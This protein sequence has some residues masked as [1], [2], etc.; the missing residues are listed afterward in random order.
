MQTALRSTLFTARP[1]QVRRSV[2]VNAKSPGTPAWAPE[3]PLWLPGTTPPAHLD[4]T[5][6]GDFGFDPLNLGANPKALERYVQ[7]EL[8]NG[9]WAMLGVAG[10]IF[11]ELLTRAGIFTAP[12]WYEAGKVSAESGAIPIAT[13]LMI[14]VFSFHF[15]E[16]KRG[17]DYEKPGSQAEPGS[18]LG[19]EAAFKGTGE[20][21]YPGGPF[22][23]LNIH[24]TP[25]YERM[26]WGEIRNAR[27]AMLAFLGFNLQ[28]LATGKSPIDN[29]VDHVANP[30]AVNFTTN[31]VSV[32][33]F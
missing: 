20:P 19:F 32:P 11:P 2:A 25:L 10:M 15:V 1:A 14:I 33:F 8:Q 23:P 5:L 3:R 30:W 7:A 22:D 6:V 27:L 21:Q 31:G 28:Y 4:G 18:F 29:L 26:K 12:N 9:R 24:K 17:M 13:Q 16:T